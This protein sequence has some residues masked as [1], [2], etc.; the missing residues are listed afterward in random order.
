MKIPISSVNLF[1]CSPRV[2]ESGLNLVLESGLSL[3]ILSSLQVLWI[4]D[5]RRLTNEELAAI[6]SYSSQCTSLKE[7][8]FGLGYTMPDTIPVGSIPSSLK[9]RNVKVW[10]N[11][12]PDFRRLNLQTGQWQACDGLGN[13]P[14]E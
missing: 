3:S 10:N 6:L 8:M 12:N 5:S 13:L 7:L 1:L 14:G 2:D 4:Y 11:K 9:S